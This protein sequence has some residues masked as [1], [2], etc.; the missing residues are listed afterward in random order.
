L[1][2]VEQLKEADGFHCFIQLVGVTTN[3][4]E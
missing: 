2:A 3:Q 4:H 1:I